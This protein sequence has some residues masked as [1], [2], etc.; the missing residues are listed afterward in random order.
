MDINRVPEISSY[1]K[2]VYSQGGE[3]GIIEEILK[4]IGREA[5]L[6]K[7][8]VEFGALDG[9][10]FSNVCNLIKNR[11]YNAIL[12][13]GDKSKYRKLC[14]NFPQENVIKLCQFVTLEGTSSLDEILGKT[15]I[16]GDFDFLS[17]DIDGCDYH[18]LKTLENYKPK[19]ICIE[20]NHYIPNEVEFVQSED[21]SV[22]H[23]SS[24]R[25][26][27]L[28]AASKGYFLAACTDC[29]LI[30]VRKEFRNDIVELKLDEVRDDTDVRTLIF[31][32]Y[33]GTLFCNKKTILVPW[34]KLSLSPTQIQVLPRYLRKFG[35]DYNFLQ[36]L[37]FAVFVLVKFPGDFASLFHQKILVK[38]KNKLA[39]LTGKRDA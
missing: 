10:R 2:S 8:C 9:I 6:D 16:P 35:E 28:L 21:F 15:N 14:K 22:K 1:A 27:I 33:D 7:W 18:I 37:L 25:S 36:K 30:F 13:E 31:F 32:G 19:V 5:S 3:D 34:H 4:R 24:A 11:D 17:I 26:M 38:L 20:F 12:I 23:G 39:C 29:N